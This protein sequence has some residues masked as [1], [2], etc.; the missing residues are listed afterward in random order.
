ALVDGARRAGQGAPEPLRL[1]LAV[2]AQ[3]ALCE[4]RDDLLTMIVTTADHA[5][6]RE[7]TLGVLAAA[8]DLAP[9]SRPALGLRVVA[10]ACNTTRLG[11][12]SGAAPAPE[13]AAFVRAVDALPAGGPYAW[14]RA[15][16]GAVWLA[17]SRTD[18]DPD[19]AER[20]WAQVSP[21]ALSTDPRAT[22][23]G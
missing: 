19:D 9:E 6:R 3:R 13:D 16:H 4:R 8:R 15:L 11:R 10:A 18:P 20:R 14:V 5:D 21:E 22:A 12:A 7:A 1:A 2:W 23:L 17:G